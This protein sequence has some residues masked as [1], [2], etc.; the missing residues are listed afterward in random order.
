MAG[1]SNP[2]KAIKYAFVANLGIAIAKGIAAAMTGS[3]S[4]LAEAIH[5]T[6][7][8]GN[9]LLLFLGIKQSTKPATPEHPLGFGMA[10][11]FWSF[12]V[13][14]IL[15]SLGGLYSLYE[16]FHKLDASEPIEQAWIA[17]TV[18]GIAIVLEGGSL[19]GCMREINAQ[20]NGRTLWRWLRESR[21]AEL[22]VVFGEDLGA[23]VGL[24]FAAVFLGLAVA[25]GDNRYDAYGSMVIG[26]VLLVIAVFVAIRV[27]ALLIG[28]SADPALSSAI[29]EAIKDNDD[30]VQVYHVITIQLGPKVLLAAKIRLADGITNVTGC[31]AI[32]VLEKSL[33]E[34]FPVIRWSFIEPDIA[35]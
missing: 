18:L 4:M 13:A 32:N 14:I 11:F 33:K 24:V 12:I 7:D 15:F 30:I 31:H 8:T 25:T 10:T 19:Y 3:S 20:R 9:Q 2:A 26:A 1:G 34:R 5:S 27:H 22:V 28:R 29:E 6:A 23:L 21:S 35:D 17:F 16:G